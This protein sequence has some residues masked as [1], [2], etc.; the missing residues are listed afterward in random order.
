MPL[1]NAPLT[2]Y[3]HP[4]SRGRVVRWMLEETGY[5]Y[6]TK[7][8]DYT[9]SM[10]APE[11]LAISPMGK[12]PAITHGDAVVTEVVAICAYLADMF[13]EAR[14]LP[15]AKD[16]K[17]KADY[18]RWLFFIAGPL[19]SAVANKLLNVTIPDDKKR[20]IG[21]GGI[22]Q[23]CS[24]LRAELKGKDFIAGNRF[25]AADLI[26]S[27]YLGFYLMFMAISPDAEFER[28]VKLHKSRPAAVRALEIDEKLAKAA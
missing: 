28:Y 6:D 10:K 27:S 15:D 17:A 4:M 22:E 12:V 7:L 24:I 3:T 21:H 11:Y 19:E 16:A 18:Y 5:P 1:I 25:S 20:A 23:V 13:P 26:V 9:T 8:L 2:F 14:L